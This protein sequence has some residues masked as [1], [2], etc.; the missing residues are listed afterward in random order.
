[1]V[2]VLQVSIGIDNHHFVRRRGYRNTINEGINDDFISHVLALVDKCA[3]GL[4]DFEDLLA[5]VFDYVEVTI[6]L[7]LVLYLEVETTT[8]ECDVYLLFVLHRLVT[9]AIPEFLEL[10]GDLG[11]FLWRIF[12]SN[13]GNRYTLALHPFPCIFLQLIR[14]FYTKPP[15]L[16][17]LIQILTLSLSKRL[18]KIPP[19]G[20]ESRVPLAKIQQV[21]TMSDTLHSLKGLLIFGFSIDVIVELAED[22]EEEVVVHVGKVEGV[23][24]AYVDRSRCLSDLYL[25]FLYLFTQEV[26]E[27]YRF[28]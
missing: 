3:V 23:I 20:D 14:R 1:M 22:E 4:A 10:Y 6:D 27:D 2:D 5:V 7:L 12:L 13:T 21:S 25:H 19:I 18:V 16:T 28:G 8:E 26:V 24:F 11:D 9:E 17:L 15:Y